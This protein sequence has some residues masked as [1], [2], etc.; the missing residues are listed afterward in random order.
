VADLQWQGNRRPPKIAQF[1]AP[2][3]E[4]AS[5][6]DRLHYC[7][8]TGTGPGAEVP[9]MSK[10]RYRRDRLPCRRSSLGSSSAEDFQRDSRHYRPLASG[11]P[12]FS[13]GSFVDN[14]GLSFR[15]FRL[16]VAPVPMISAIVTS[17]A[18]PIALVRSSR[19]H[20]GPMLFLPMAFR[21]WPFVSWTARPPARRCQRQS[22]RRSAL[23]RLVVSR[24]GFWD[25]I[26][27]SISREDG[28]GSADD[29]TDRH[30]PWFPGS[31]IPRADTS[32]PQSHE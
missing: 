20:A 5:C 7:L 8:S 6:I 25:R 19:V 2:V 28:Y 32:V 21:S 10:P 9:G 23:K 15:Q 30:R 12:A 4:N 17:S 26:Q 11:L 18:R 27:S 3:A 16:F 14:P 13:S 24:G 1:D 31:P 29:H 22:G